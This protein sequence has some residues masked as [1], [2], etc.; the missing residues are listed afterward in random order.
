MT[1]CREDALALSA[2]VAAWQDS[3]YEWFRLQIQAE[4]AALLGDLPR[5][6]ELAR[7]LYAHSGGNFIMENNHANPVWAKLRNYPLW[8][9]FVAPR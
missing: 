7:A 8:V 9:A 4:I 3:R 5:A 2:R 1:A 6:V